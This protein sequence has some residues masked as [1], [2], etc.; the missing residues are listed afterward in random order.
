MV[1]VV[2]F[3]DHLENFMAICYNL[4]PFGIVCGNLLCFTNLVH[5]F[6]PRKIRQ[7]CFLSRPFPFRAT[8]EVNGMHRLCKQRQFIKVLY[9]EK[10]KASTA[11]L[12]DFS[13]YKIPKRE[14]I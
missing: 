10:D 3:Y 2:I 13:W 14:K 8:L 1:N 5:I 12:P 9:I 11:G 4:W 6:G 7:P